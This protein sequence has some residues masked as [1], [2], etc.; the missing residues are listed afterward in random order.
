MSS[1][2]PDGELVNSV[3]KDFKAS[4]WSQSATLIGQI[5][6]TARHKPRHAANAVQQRLLGAVGDKDRS[7]LSPEGRRKSF[8]STQFRSR[9]ISNNSG[10]SADHNTSPLRT[11]TSQADTSD[12]EGQSSDDDANEQDLIHS[13][14]HIRNGS[15]YHAPDVGTDNGHSTKALELAPSLLRKSLSNGSSQGANASQ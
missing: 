5:L 10:M 6:T 12:A 7:S 8:M 13:N 11:V 4:I 15:L 14:E 9:T 1:H 3:K 2:T